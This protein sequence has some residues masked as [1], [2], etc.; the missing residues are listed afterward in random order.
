MNTIEML[1]QE[2][3]DFG[4]KGQGIMDLSLWLNVKLQILSAIDIRHM[5]LPG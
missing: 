4:E 2:S 5:F 3:R 1:L